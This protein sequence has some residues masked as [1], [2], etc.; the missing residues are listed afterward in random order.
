MGEAGGLVVDDEDAFWAKV[1]FFEEGE[2]GDAF[3]HAGGKED[4]LF[5]EDPRKGFEESLVAFKEDFFFGGGSGAEVDV[6]ACELFDG[7][8]GHFRGSSGHSHDGVVFFLEFLE[9]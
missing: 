5:E 7:K 3:I 6:D 2:E 8:G 9:E 4:A 1:E